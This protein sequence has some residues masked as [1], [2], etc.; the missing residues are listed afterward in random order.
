[1]LV[2]KKVLTLGAAKRI[3]AAAEQ[4][5]AK[6]KWNVVVAVV[7]DG[8][9]LLLLHRMDN[10][11]LA[12]VEVGF[13]KAKAAM[14]FKRPTKTL[15]DVVTGGRNVMMKLANIVPVE[16]GVPLEVDGQIVGAIGVSGVTSVQDGVIA[17]AAV[18]EF[19]RIVKG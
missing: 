13:Q 5:A 15:E 16:G 19:A 10:T 17:Q 11:Q 4:E 2:T 18:D 9:H 6:H 7:D 3:A 14:L 1:M 12:S 8:G